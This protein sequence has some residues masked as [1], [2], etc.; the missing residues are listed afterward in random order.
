MFSKFNKCEFWLKVVFLGHVILGEVIYIDLRKVEVVLEYEILVNVIEILN[1]LR[2]AG[3][4]KRF[5]KGFLKI[6]T[7]LT[8]L[9]WKKVR[10]EWTRKYK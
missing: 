2:L 3:Y 7:L 4:Y 10:W 1:F 9:T 8:R 5:I 6:K